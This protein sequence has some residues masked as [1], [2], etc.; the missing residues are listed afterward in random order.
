MSVTVTGLKEAQRKFDK[1]SDEMRGKITE[2]ALTKSAEVLRQDMYN[3]C[4][5]KGG[6]SADGFY[7]SYSKASGRSGAVRESLK[8][9][10]VQGVLVRVGTNNPIAPQLEYGTSRES[11]RPFAR[12]AADDS[13]TR[14]NI[15]KTF[16]EEVSKG[17]KGAAR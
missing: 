9:G 15:K 3:K 11:A 14:N 2:A 6:S 12:R 8:A 5:V 10:S 7:K 4:P 17:V 13:Q 16:A 1:L